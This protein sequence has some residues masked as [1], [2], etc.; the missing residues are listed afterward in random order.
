MTPPNE[1]SV[2][3]VGVNKQSEI[4]FKGRGI[5]RNRK[6]RRNRLR[7]R[8]T[9]CRPSRPSEGRA[10]LLSFLSDMAYMWYDDYIT[11]R[12]YRRW[13]KDVCIV[14]FSYECLRG[15]YEVGGWC[16]TLFTWALYCETWPIFRH[17]SSDWGFNSFQAFP[18]VPF[19]LIIRLQPK[20]HFDNRS[21]SA[22]WTE[23][24][25]QPCFEIQ[26]RWRKLSH[27]K[28]NIYWRL[29]V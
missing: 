15:F 16:G 10:Y 3:A 17:L 21:S 20:R 13:V 4:C 14:S 9:K 22:L 8:H 29:G 28:N 7:V 23:V 24:T 18:S 26:L 19:P 6:R 25:L 2:T 1:G 11:K 27:M 5:K 12:L